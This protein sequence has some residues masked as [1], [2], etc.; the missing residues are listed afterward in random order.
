MNCCHNLSSIKRSKFFGAEGGELKSRIQIFSH[1]SA[2]EIVGLKTHKIIYITDLGLS[3]S[4]WYSKVTCLY[5]VLK[6]PRL[7]QSQGPGFT[8]HGCLASDITKALTSTFMNFLNGSVSM[9]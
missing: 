1:G 5:M 6:A 4:L 3:Y 9:L 7:S 8:K 2:R